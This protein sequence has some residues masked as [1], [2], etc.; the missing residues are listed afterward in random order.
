MTET[1]TGALNLGQPHDPKMPRHW[2]LR[3]ATVK[4]ASCPVVVEVDGESERVVGTCE[5]WA[6]A[7]LLNSS[8]ILL[9]TLALVARTHLGTR[10]GINS[11][12]LMD[13]VVDAVELGIGT[14]HAE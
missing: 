12:Q 14:R 13:L 10:G 4:G 1:A 9:S 3:K 7:Q 11:K 2:V 5:T 8:T 6:D